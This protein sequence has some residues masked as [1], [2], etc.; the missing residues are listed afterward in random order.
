MSIMSIHKHTGILQA[1][2]HFYKCKTHN[3]NKKNY[4]YIASYE[5]RD[6]DAKQTILIKFSKFL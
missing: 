2:G 3:T 1:E 5:Q 4:V 6:L